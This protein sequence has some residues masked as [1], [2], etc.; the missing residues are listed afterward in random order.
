MQA[1]PTP[2]PSLTAAQGDVLLKLARQTLS[3]QL[4]SPVPE[5]E[6]AAVAEALNTP[7]FQN[8]CGTFVTLKIKGELRGCI[9]SLSTRESIAQG[10]RDNVV[11]AAFRD[12]RFR[13]LLLQELSRVAIEVSVLSDPKP[14]D[15]EHADDLLTRLQPGI[16]GVI[17]RQGGASATFL[18]QVW[19]QLPHPESFLTHLC[20][21]AGLARD[22][23][24]TQH[25][26]I[27]T[28]QVQYFE[29][30]H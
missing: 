4:G 17:L 1:G 29:E 28:Y 5:A 25:P 24:R 19:E 3:D 9:G 20:L 11:N 10:V 13:P 27:L 16:D 18:P 30:S 15:Y 26:D 8:H 6:K 12:P 23:W 2:S 14:L 22:A 7:V 21:K